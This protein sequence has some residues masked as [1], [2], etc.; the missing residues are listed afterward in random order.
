MFWEH[1]HIYI[2]AVINKCVILVTGFPCSFLDLGWLLTTALLITAKPR[3]TEVSHLR[4]TGVAAENV[5]PFSCPSA[6]IPVCPF[7]SVNLF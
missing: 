2:G 6:R 1:M 5:I 7:F 3:K 4:K